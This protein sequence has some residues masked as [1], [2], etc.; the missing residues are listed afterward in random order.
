MPRPWQRNNFWQSIPN[1]TGWFQVWL[2]PRGSGFRR[3]Q[4]FP[5]VISKRQIFVGQLLLNFLDRFTQTNSAIKPHLD[6]PQPETG[7]GLM[8]EPGYVVM[9]SKTGKAGAH[10]LPGR[11]EIS[12]VEIDNG[13]SQMIA[14]VEFVLGQQAA[15]QAIYQG[16]DLSIRHYFA[17]ASKEKRPPA[18]ASGRCSSS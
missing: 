8:V 13:N 17:F 5:T 18:N 1:R 10:T 12:R 3:I 7:E 11:G 9:S 6:L 14:V 4:Q 2:Y 16:K 15:L